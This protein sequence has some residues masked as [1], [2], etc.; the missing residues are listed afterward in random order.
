MRMFE[1]IE[2]YFRYLKM[3]FFLFHNRISS[4]A[5]IACLLHLY[6]PNIITMM[7]KNVHNFSY[8]VG[9]GGAELGSGPL[10]VGA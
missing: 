2:S 3:F 6:V 4:L 5:Q 10:G 1:A 9:W 7:A 8:W